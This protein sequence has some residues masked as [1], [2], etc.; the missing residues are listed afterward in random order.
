MAPRLP[1]ALLALGAMVLSAATARGSWSEAQV[2]PGARTA[3]LVSTALA[4]DGRGTTAVAWV[5]DGG[6]TNG[7]R[8][9]TTAVRVAVRRAGA[10]FSVRTLARRRDLA[11]QGLNAAM[12]ARGELTV[13]WIDAVPRAHRTVRSAFRTS[14]GRWSAV[15][16][17]GFS[18]AFAY[19]VPRLAVAPDRR[20]LLSYVAGVRVAP[21]VG[22]AWRR[23]GHRFGAVQ[24]VGR[25]RI[26]DPVPAFDPAG[27]AYLSGIAQCD[28]ESRSHGVVRLTAPRGRRFGAPITVTPAPATELHLRLTGPGTAVAG[29][30]GA[31]CSTTE[32][33]SGAILAARMQGQTVTNRQ[34]VYQGVGRGL[35]LI[36]APAAGVDATWTAFPASAPG[37]ALLAARTNASGAFSAPLVPTDGWYP[38]VADDS[39]DQIVATSKP[40]AY[41]Q[42]GSVGARSATASAIEPSPLPGPAW[43]SS[44]ASPAGTRALA[45]VSAAGGALRVATWT[46]GG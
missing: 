46:P 4:V 5:D 29:W 20:V 40:E 27:R 18:S 36:G 39:G 17:V 19:A 26:F 2:V 3:T 24:G 35:A 7:K 37:G 28:D 11:V 23:P 43:F 38:V 13:A 32:L 45:A 21:G 44:A 22:V 34:V 12:D 9:T 6:A 25:L 10:G 14:T 8:H 41:G 31:G 33:L 1:L 42:P 15:Q 30:V 16:A